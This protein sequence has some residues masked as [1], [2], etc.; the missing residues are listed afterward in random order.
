VNQRTTRQWLGMGML[1]VLV[2][3]V[4]LLRLM[5]DHDPITDSLSLAWPAEQYAAYRYTALYIG[6][7]VGVALAI[8]GVL[9]QALLRNPLASPF[10]LGVSSGAGLGVMIALYI[11]HQTGLAMTW[12]KAPAAAIGALA[13]LGIVYALG[14]RRGALDPVS[15][16]LIGVVISTIASAGI[17]FFQHLVKAGLLAEFTQW[18]MGRVP[19]TASNAAL[20]SAGAATLGG[21]VIAFVLGRAMDVASLG[22]DEAHSVGLALQPLRAAL[23]VIAGLLTA[24]TV[25]LAGPIGFVGLIAPHAGRLLLGPGHRVLV[26]GAALVGVVL[27]VG[28][29]AARQ[30]IEFGAGRMPVGIFTALIGGPTFLWLLLSGRARYGG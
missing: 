4:A 22:D 29:D 28:S 27:V 13:S 8:S 3:V 25:A 7:I 6:S 9:L 2:G 5:I 15:L 18:I 11:T 14:R 23:F 24:M 16:V 12:G 10:I 21:V 30:A 1:I 17:M 20:W 19:E 26:I